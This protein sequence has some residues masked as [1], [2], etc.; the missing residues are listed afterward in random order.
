LPRKADTVRLDHERQDLADVTRGFYDVPVE[1][2]VG[3]DIQYPGYLLQP[4]GAHPVDAFLVFLDLLEA[5]PQPFAKIR[6]AESLGA[7]LNLDAL[8]DL[9]VLG[10]GC[11]RF[12]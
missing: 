4:D 12:R 1:K 11:A 5:N 9:H 7:S 2:V 3:A 8:T 6:L 10:G